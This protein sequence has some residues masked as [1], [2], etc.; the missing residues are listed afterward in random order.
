MALSMTKALSRVLA[1]SPRV[2]GGLRPSSPLQSQW[3]ALCSRLDE[4]HTDSCLLQ[5]QRLSV[6][7]KRIMVRIPFFFKTI[8]FSFFFFLNVKNTSVQQRQTRRAGGRAACR[9]VHW[10]LPLCNVIVLNLKRTGPQLSLRPSRVTGFEGS[11][12]SW[13]LLMPLC[14]SSLQRCSRGS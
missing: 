6:A 8:L 3:V 9:G 1:W 2:H 7:L 14:L 4:H 12:S 13:N 5:A 11:A 10:L